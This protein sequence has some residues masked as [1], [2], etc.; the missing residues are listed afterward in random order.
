[1]LFRSIDTEGA[2]YLRFYTEGT[3][4]ADE[5]VGLDRIMTNSG[6]LF[7]INAATYNLWKANTFAVGGALTLAK[8]QEG[9]AVAAQ[10]GLS[11]DVELFVNPAVWQ[12]L[13]TEQV[14]YRMMDSSYSNKKGVNGFEGLE[15]HSQNGKITVYAH[16]YVK[17][18]E[19][20]LLPTRRAVRIGSSDISF[21]IPGTDNGQIFIQNPT[22]A[23][24]Q[25]RIFSQQ[26]LLVVKPALC[27]KF[28]GIA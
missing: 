28:T 3:N 16:K 20:F 6:L 27:V 17:E 7:N 22:S 15:F 11:E 4:G 23:G 1:V 25:F 21:N 19:A 2:G 8:I 26:A 10:R 14:T 12:D 13:S 5:A 24:F 18:G 9:V